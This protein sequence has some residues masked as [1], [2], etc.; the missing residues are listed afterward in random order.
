MVEETL[1]T[2]RF[3]KVGLDAKP[4]IAVPVADGPETVI[5][6]DEALRVISGW[7]EVE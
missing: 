4:T 6:D 5:F 7:L 2:V 1:V 3:P